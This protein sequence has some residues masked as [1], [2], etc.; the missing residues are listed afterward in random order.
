MK[1][2]WGVLALFGGLAV[3]GC[4]PTKAQDMA[5][6]QVKAA[7]IYPHW[8]D[9]PA[10]AAEEA[11]DYIFNCM[12]VKGYVADARDTSCQIPVEWM[13]RQNQLCYRKPLIPE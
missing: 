3:A 7:E 11:T 12:T 9:Q 6:C 8:K 13:V 1:L 2:G 5:E 4:G 10:P